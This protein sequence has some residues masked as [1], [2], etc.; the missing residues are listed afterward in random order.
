MINLLNLF[1]ATFI[2]KRKT[3]NDVIENLFFTAENTNQK[4]KKMFYTKFIIHTIIDKFVLVLT[5]HVHS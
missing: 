3:I 2:K 5:F 1:Y 4:K